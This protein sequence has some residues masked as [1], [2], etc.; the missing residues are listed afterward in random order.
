MNRL[1]PREKEV[2]LNLRK[3]L[4]FTEKDNTNDLFTLILLADIR[5]QRLKEENIMLENKINKMEE[6]W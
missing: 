3:T 5:I 1:N 4:G 2:L 6:V